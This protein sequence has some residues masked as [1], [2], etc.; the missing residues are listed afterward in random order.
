MGADGGWG[1]R[2]T[3]Q[4]RV[5]DNVEFAAIYAFAPALTPGPD[6]PSALNSSPA[7]CR[8]YRHSLAGRLL[9]TVPMLFFSAVVI[10][11]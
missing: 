3:Y 1:T 11:R 2:V 4:E 5:S 9:A 6:E 7:F 8:T 10:S